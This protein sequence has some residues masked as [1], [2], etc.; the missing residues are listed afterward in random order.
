MNTTDLRSLDWPELTSLV[1]VDQ[2]WGIGREG[3]QLFYL[4]GDLQR[5]KK[6]TMGATVICGRRTLATFPGGQALEGRHNVIVTRSPE[7]FKN[8]AVT[9]VSSL[10]DLP[11]VLAH[12][13]EPFF[14]IGGAS[15]YEQLLPVT[16]FAEV[17][18]VDTIVPDADRFHPNLDQDPAWQLDSQSA[19]MLD[20]RSGLSYAYRRYSRR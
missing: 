6:L 7:Q 13:P 20:E 10:A 5:F 16:S 4:R 19:S 1:V 15:I 2:N 11:E 18:M 14:V 12:L 17:T 9:A 8:A 3:D